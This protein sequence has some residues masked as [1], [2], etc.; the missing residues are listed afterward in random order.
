MSASSG[1]GAG[2]GSGDASSSMF[3]EGGPS[4]AEAAVLARTGALGIAGLAGL[5]RQTMLLPFPGFPF[6]ADSPR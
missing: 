4:A 3:S 1:G 2:A 5:L 6:A